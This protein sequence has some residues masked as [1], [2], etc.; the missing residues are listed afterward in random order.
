MNMASLWDRDLIALFAA[1]NI[2]VGDHDRRTR[3]TAAS[4][5]M[6][7]TSGRATRTASIAA[8]V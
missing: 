3:L 1:L 7:I 8:S 6:T 5:S 4:A 2:D